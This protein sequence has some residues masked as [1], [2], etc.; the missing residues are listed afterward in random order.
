MLVAGPGVWS[1]ELEAR[2]NPLGG[3]VPLPTHWASSV[4]DDSR[5]KGDF[6]G[7]VCV[8]RP[9]LLWFECPGAHS[10]LLTPDN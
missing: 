4:T 1:A 7:H 10:T 5:E 9:H 3:A 2:W 8:P 6:K